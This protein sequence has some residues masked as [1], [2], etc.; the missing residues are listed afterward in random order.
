MI[1]S[2]YPIAIVEPSVT[3]ILPKHCV[4]GNNLN[5]KYIISSENGIKPCFLEKIPPSLDNGMLTLSLLTP[6][7]KLLKLV[8]IPNLSSISYYTKN[9]LAG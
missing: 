8:S 7:A 2:S 4:T 6:A 1:L 9:S 5:V 3:N